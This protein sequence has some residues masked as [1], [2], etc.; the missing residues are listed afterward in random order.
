[1][2]VEKRLRL[3]EKKMRALKWKENSTEVKSLLKLLQSNKVILDATLFVYTFS[4]REDS[5]ALKEAM[6]ATN[7]AYT[8]GLRIGAGSDHMISLGDYQKT[9]NIHKELEL[10]VDAGLSNYDALRA[11]TINNA[12]ILGES[13]RIGTIEEGKLAN[14][15]V[16]KAD[17][18]KDIT[19]TRS[20]EY[21]IKRGKI[22]DIKRD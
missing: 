17:P 8:N 18:T 14:L 9:I 22:Y 3:I 11:A 20:I 7:W 10:L 13:D 2:Q 12:A 1:M 16:L 19:R 6:R 15:V 21:V 4:I 5:T